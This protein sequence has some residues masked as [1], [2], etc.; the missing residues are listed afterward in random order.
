MFAAKRVKTSERDPD[1][2]EPPSG[3]M[4]GIIHAKVVDT[5][6]L[7]SMH[8]TVSSGTLSE[9]ANEENGVYGLSIIL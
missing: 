9:I 2:V 4:A 7:C 5:T 3:S 6:S 8:I 1:V